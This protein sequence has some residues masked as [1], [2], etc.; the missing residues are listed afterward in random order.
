MNRFLQLLTLLFILGN[1]LC[2]TEKIHLTIRYLGLPVVRV[3]MIDNGKE[4][5][6]TAKATTIAS[7]AASMDNKYFS[8]YSDDYLTERYRKII[9]Q[10]GYH[11]DRITMYDRDGSV[12]RR[13][14]YILPERDREYPIVKDSRDFFSALFYLRKMINTQSKGVIWLDANSLIWKAQFEIIGT[15]NLKTKLGRM[16]AVKVKFTFQQI[17]EEEKEN[18]DMLTNNLVNE[19]R[20]LYFWLS[21]D[22]R[23]IPLKAK[24][25]MK[26]FSVTWKLEN[27]TNE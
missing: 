8:T 24:F 26:P 9:N 16:D 2:A 27:Y 23:K 5:K 17:S 22:E 15:E 21:N 19:E 4:I 13:T 7:I 11:E 25:M 20:A 3:K 10:R 6:V 1:S 18:S 14:S 12:A